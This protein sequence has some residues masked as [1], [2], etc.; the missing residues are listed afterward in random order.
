[1]ARAQGSVNC[2]AKP[3]HPLKTYSWDA[4]SCVIDSSHSRDSA[5]LGES[6]CSARFTLAISHVARGQA[7][8]RQ[9][10]DLIARAENHHPLSLNLLEIMS[11]ARRCILMTTA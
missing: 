4:G 5:V 6:I 10:S 11:S 2:V 1:M 9:C 8:K 7:H 3:S